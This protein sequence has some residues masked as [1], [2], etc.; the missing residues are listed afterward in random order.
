MVNGE[1]DGLVLT[2][3]N[4]QNASVQATRS[5][6]SIKILKFLRYVIAKHILPYP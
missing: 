4:T 1:L 2:K 5:I 3:S 6:L